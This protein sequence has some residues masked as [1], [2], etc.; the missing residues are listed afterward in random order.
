MKWRN[1][2][3]FHVPIP[4]QY[5]VDTNC[6]GHC[7]F[8]TKV[9]QITFLLVESNSKKG[10]VCLRPGFLQFTSF[11]SSSTNNIFVHPLAQSTLCI[12]SAKKISSSKPYEPSII[13]SVK[14]NHVLFFYFSV[15]FSCYLHDFKFYSTNLLKSKSYLCT[16]FYNSSASFRNSVS[17]SHFYRSCIKL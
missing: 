11:M 17:H 6:T 1:R 10:C 4:W 8:K 16:L 3:V 9:Y 15:T 13:S 14:H 5:S 12:S 2:N 7:S